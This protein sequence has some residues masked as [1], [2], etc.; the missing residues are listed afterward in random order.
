M[1]SQI[2]ARSTSTGIGE[3]DYTTT[4]TDTFTVRVRHTLPSTAGG[5]GSSSLVTLVKVNSTTKY[6]SN[7]GDNGLEIQV[8]CTSG[9]TIKVITSSAAA[10]DNVI[11]AIKTTIMISQGGSL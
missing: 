4:A 9:D 3:F 2:K 1:A 10:N 11:N 8:A 5:N 7:A 6:T